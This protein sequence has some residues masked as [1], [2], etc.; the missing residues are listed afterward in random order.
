[1]WD[2][3]V[4]I[5]LVNPSKFG[6]P[7][8]EGPALESTKISAP[9]ADE[10]RFYLKLPTMH[11]N[12]N[13]PFSLRS[14]SVKRDNVYKIH[15]YQAYKI[16]VP[17]PDRFDQPPNCSSSWP[18]NDTKYRAVALDNDS[19]CP[20][21]IWGQTPTDA[22]ACSVGFSCK[23]RITLPDLNFHDTPDQDWFSVQAGEFGIGAN[24]VFRIEANADVEIEAYYRHIVNAVE[25]ETLLAKGTRS[26]QLPNEIAGLTSP[27][28]IKV[29][30]PIEGM[31]L[32]YDLEFFRAKKGF[33]DQLEA[34]KWHVW[35][36]KYLPV[37][38]DFPFSTI[39]PDEVSGTFVR[40]L[41]DEGR[42]TTPDEYELAWQ[43]QA[44]SAISI[45]LHNGNSLKAEILDGTGALMAS[46]EY[47]ANSSAGQAGAFG[48]ASANETSSQLALRLDTSGLE[49][50][51]TYYLRLSNAFPG[52]K[53]YVSLPAAGT[54]PGQVLSQAC[55]E[56]FC[57]IAIGT[58]TDGD[59][60]PDSADA[61]PL[62]SAESLDTDGDGIGNNGDL[63][64]DD[65]GYSDAEELQAGTDPLDSA[66]FPVSVPTLS[67]EKSVL[68][69]LLLGSIGIATFARGRPVRRA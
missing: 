36:S 61:F 63:D 27:L 59:D 6:L 52:T 47:F 62:D 8:I 32:E 57:R 48:M 12:T 26:L 25:V 15:R 10:E 60:V 58:D 19:S 17:P 39:L 30:P 45:E 24:D 37:P 4:D 9:S 44:D 56:G 11:S 65:D 55:P 33:L 46:A 3:H 20:D 23:Y 35:W 29:A 18:D 22:Q 51:N 40:L 49:G 7:E 69:L 50:G 54:A 21:V 34:F 1:M 28:L 38:R 66:S 41:D 43:F 13:Y 42:I 67:P 2:T 5:D 14:V 68:L 53:V 31:F 64:D 16:P